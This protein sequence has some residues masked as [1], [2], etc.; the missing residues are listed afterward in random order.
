MPPY[1]KSMAIDYDRLNEIL[2]SNARPSRSTPTHDLAGVTIS[3][4][5]S[6]DIDKSDLDG[7]S[8]LVVTVRATYDAAATTG[9]RVRWLYSPDGTNY[10]TVEDAE[11]Q[12]NYEDLSFAAG[13]TRQRTAIV[14]IFAPYVKIQV[15]NLDTS[16]PVTVDAWTTLMR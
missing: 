11:A 12:G 14:P 8:A 6:Q 13:E 7:Y 10:D 4:G 9:V 5:G 3:A 1:G 2:S 16:A 15:V